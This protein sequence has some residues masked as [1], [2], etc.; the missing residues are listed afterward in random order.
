MDQKLLRDAARLVDQPPRNSPRAGGMAAVFQ[1]FDS[2]V[3]FLRELAALL[4]EIG[5]PV[6][7]EIRDALERRDAGRLE[8][9]AHRLKG[10]L[11]PFVAPAA[12]NAAQSLEDMGHVDDLSKALEVYQV[13]DVD[14]QRLLRGAQGSNFR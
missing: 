2:D 13:L 12:M 10:S 14:V 8:Q 3:G 6:L 5:P 7:A 4:E 9:A 11:I 1:H